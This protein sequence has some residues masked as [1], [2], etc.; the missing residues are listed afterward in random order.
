MKRRR[1]RRS[2]KLD[3]IRGRL[4]EATTELVAMADETQRVREQRAK[5]RPPTDDKARSV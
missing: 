5:P 2:L 4:D 3:A 1:R